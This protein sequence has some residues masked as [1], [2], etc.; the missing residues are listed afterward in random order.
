MSIHPTAI[1]ESGACIGRN[2]SIGPY[3]YVGRDVTIGDD[4]TL[5]HHASIEGFTT[6][7]SRCEVF[8]QAVLGAP[9][10]D[11]KFSGERTFLEIG[12]R[13]IFREMVTVHPGTGNGG[14]ITHIG[15]DN[16]FLI[17]VHVAHDCFVGN[18]CIIAN[19]VQFAGH[20]R[21]EDH[22]NM[23]GCTAVH[24]FVTIGKHAFIGGMTR[25][26]ADVPPYVVMVAARGTRSEIRMING[27][28][29][30]RSGFSQTDIAALKD[31]FMQ[32][33]SRRARNSGIVMTDRVQVMLEVP[34][35]NPHVR[36]LC[37]FL[38]RS[39]AH[40]RHGRYLESLRN[41]PVH[42]DSWK[43]D[44]KMTA[45]VMPTSNLTTSDLS[46]NTSPSPSQG[47]GRVRVETKEP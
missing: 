38:M 15:N 19:G 9:P 29:L 8:P 18:R 34:G 45:S 1:I 20:V 6:L 13:N 37:E 14:G 16:L 35:L 12:D 5:H 36:N 3:C 2:V 28:G 32:L 23:G 10:Q 39:F 26:S 43:L 47:E 21:V 27:V 11:V 7:G 33:F 40:G 22:V 25:V 31:A 44:G 41:D 4:C 42:R 17:G 30:E 24:H 46:G